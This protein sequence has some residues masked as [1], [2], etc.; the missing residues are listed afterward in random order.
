MAHTSRSSLMQEFLVR[1]SADDASPGLEVETMSSCCSFKRHLSARNSEPQKRTPSKHLGSQFVASFRLLW[2]SGQGVG[3][4]ATQPGL[5]ARSLTRSLLIS[6]C[7]IVTAGPNTLQF[8]TDQGGGKRRSVT[9]FC[10]IAM[11]V[12]AT[13]HPAPRSAG[14]V[15]SFEHL[16]AG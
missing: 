10:H 2:L 16:A 13:T 4:W 1:H 12:I 3:G 15:F 5:M 9:A 7:K 11:E 14:F 8:S 6:L